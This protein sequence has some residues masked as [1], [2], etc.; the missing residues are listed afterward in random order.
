MSEVDVGINLAEVGV[1]INLAEVGINLAEVGINLAEVDY[2]HF[3]Q[4]MLGQNF[5]VCAGTPGGGFRRIQK[6]ARAKLTLATTLNKLLLLLTNS[7]MYESSGTFVSIQIMPIVK[8]LFLT[9]L[10]LP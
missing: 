8:P 10:L 9:N 4:I 5:F 7:I 3:K 2:A 6:I 1:G